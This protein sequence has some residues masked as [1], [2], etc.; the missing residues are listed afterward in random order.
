V[1]ATYLNGLHL[2]GRDP[3]KEL[4]RLRPAAEVGYSIMVYDLRQSDAQHAFRE[5][6]KVLH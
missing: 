3:F 2:S 5:A 4:R 1:S 6:L